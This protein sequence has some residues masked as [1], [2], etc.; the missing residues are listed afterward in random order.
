MDK[1]VAVEDSLQDYIEFLEKSGYEVDRIQSPA[2][3]NMV[4]SFDYDAVVVSVV[5]ESAMRKST[6]FQTSDRP[7][8]PIVEA[9]GK[10]PEE[11]FNILRTR[12]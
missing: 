4:Q 11:V 3:A 7:S 5:D 12:H 9:R 10:T 8:A 6:F 1:R 2:D